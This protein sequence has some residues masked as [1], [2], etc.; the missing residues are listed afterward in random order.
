MATPQLTVMTQAGAVRGRQADG[1]LEFLGTPYADPPAIPSANC[2]NLNLYTLGPGRTGL[3]VLA[4]STVV[5]SS[6]AAT[7]APG[8]T[9]DGLPGTASC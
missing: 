8:T 6:P 4:W 9:A 2:L 7:P 5:L 1:C 3:P